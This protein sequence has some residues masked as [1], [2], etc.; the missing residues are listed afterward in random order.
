M[1]GEMLQ[2]REA[3]E[4]SWNEKTSYEGGFDPGNPSQGQCYP[5]ARVVQFYFPKG[6]I[7][8]GEVWTGEKL[9]KH[10]WV[11]FECDGVECPVDFTW[12]QF[13][14]GSVVK[15]WKIRDRKTLGDGRE[16]KARVGIL[17][18]RVEEYLSQ[19]SPKRARKQSPRRSSRIKNEKS[20]KV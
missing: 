20:S 9:E 3:L 17:R 16:T 19:K 7:A 8:E 15:S 11:L 5:T 1:K 2:L 18:R 13:P 12:E 4:A 10:F 6:E 14:K